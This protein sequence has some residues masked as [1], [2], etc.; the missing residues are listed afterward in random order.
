MIERDEIDMVSDKNSISFET[1]AYIEDATE[2]LNAKKY[3]KK[4]IVRASD[5]KVDDFFQEASQ[6]SDLYHPLCE[7]LLEKAKTEHARHQ[8]RKLQA[9]IE[10]KCFCGG[11]KD[12]ERKLWEDVVCKDLLAIKVYAQ[13]SY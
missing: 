13:I 2:M 4:F 6:F 9:V 7:M 5:E 3:L 11:D 8:I 1:A 10:L 12:L